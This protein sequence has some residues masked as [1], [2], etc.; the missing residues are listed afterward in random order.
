MLGIQQK[1]YLPLF[2]FIATTFFFYLQVFLYSVNIPY[3]DDYDVFLAF[4]LDFQ[5][6]NSDDY[7]ARFYSFFGLHNEHRPVTARAAAY[8]SFLLADRIDFSWLI[9]L[10]SLWVLGIFLMYSRDMRRFT[11]SPLQWMIPCFFLFQHRYGQITFF[12]TASWTNLP[13]F[14]FSL[15]FLH[16]LRT[17]GKTTA[18]LGAGTLAALSNGDGLLAFPAGLILLALEKRKREFFGCLG[19][20][21]ALVGWYA[22][23][24]FQ[25]GGTSSPSARLDPVAVFDFFLIFIGSA[26]GFA[27]I[28]FARLAGAL[29]FLSSL[30]ILYKERNRG[31]RRHT[32]LLLYLL[33]TAAA[34]AVRRHELGPER[35]MQYAYTFY[36]IFFLLPTLF[37]F[38]EAA[39]RR[40]ISLGAA[41]VALG[42]VFFC[43]QYILIT[44]RLREFNQRLQRAMEPQS[45]RNP[46]G[47][48]AYPNPERARELLGRASRKG[49]YE[50]AG[51][52]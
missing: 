44:P 18:A 47:P 22:L 38:L 21:V 2:F 6:M 26:P 16:L 33:L 42:A 15:L 49:I 52:P 23:E 14:F 10:G 31:D 7:A 48:E 1:F 51:P 40:G 32:W 50:Y 8:T 11:A 20:F 9:R 4:I 3:W 46:P 35:G 17:P 37:Y 39:K 36:S 30:Y 41:L 13:S 24:S 12:A 19:L 25:T 28:H 34:V 43:L 45:G 29:L 5:E 27:H